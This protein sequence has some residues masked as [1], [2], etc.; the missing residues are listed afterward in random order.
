MRIALLALSGLLALPPNAVP[1]E[2]RLRVLVETDVGGDA[3]DQASLVRF[4]LYSNEWDV[5]GIICN[6]PKARDRENLNPVRTGLGIGRRLVDAYGECHP[7]LVKHDPRYPT[8]DELKKRTVA[9]Y[10][11]TEDAVKLIIAALDRDDP[12]P[13]WYS[14]WGTDKESGPNNLKRALDRAVKAVQALLGVDQISCERAV[15][16]PRD[17]HARGH[18]VAQVLLL[19]QPQDQL[20]E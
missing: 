13:L 17:A 1:A 2:E 10:H 4:L 6:R 15:L 16:D 5:E 11:D 8:K 14:D 18:A 3:D 7:R 12:R 20:D 19:H 9:G